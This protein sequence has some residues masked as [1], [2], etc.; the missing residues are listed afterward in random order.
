[1]RFDL[2]RRV[3]GHFV[4]LATKSIFEDI[5]GAVAVLGALIR[6][7]ISKVEAP[8]W[9][10]FE[11]GAMVLLMIAAYF[12]LRSTFI[13]WK[14][15]QSEPETRQI[16]SLL[17]LPGNTKSKELVRTPHPRF[18]Q[19]RLIFIGLVGC[20][21][22]F[23]SFIGVKSIVAKFQPKE[24]SPLASQVRID[25]A[26][27]PSPIAGKKMDVSLLYSNRGPSEV[28]IS[29]AA[30]TVIASK[31]KLQGEDY[32][33][34][35]NDGP[36]LEKKLWKSFEDKYQGD[37]F[38]SSRAFTT[39]AFIE[40][41]LIVHGGILQDSNAADLQANNGNVFI[42]TFAQI[43]WVVHGTTGPVYGYDLWFHNR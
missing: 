5:I 18:Y 1:M 37:V 19:I 43:R 27:F 30:M 32:S 25:G 15:I 11:E 24:I 41:Y 6:P 22:L 42:Y 3:S 26:R 16:E 34:D 2:L 9:R 31:T 33:V 39:P 40:Q 29:T 38:K 36:D 28:D 12:L 21:I 8:L 17:Y 14:E 7:F 20:L 13:V 10:A 4:I 35:A 23:V